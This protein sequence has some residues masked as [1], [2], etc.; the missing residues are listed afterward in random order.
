MKQSLIKKMDALI[1]GKILYI[2]T[3]LISVMLLISVVISGYQ[4]SFVKSEKQRSQEN[5][6]WAIA[7]FA[8]KLAEFNT[9]AE[10]NIR[11][12]GQNNKD[13]DF[14]LDILFSRANVIRNKSPSTK[15]LYK[16]PSYKKTI[17]SIYDR[18]TLIDNEIKKTPIRYSR[19]K[20]I[21]DSIS[22]YVNTLAN[23]ADHAEVKQRDDNYQAYLNAKSSL[24]HFIL[25][26]SIIGLL[27]ILINIRQYFNVTESLKS[28]KQAFDN[29]NAFIGML[30]HELRTSLQAIMSSVDLL[31]MNAMDEKSTFL[32]ESAASQMERQM[33]DLTEF[34]K[35]DNGLIEIR[36]N[37]F[38]LHQVVNTLILECQLAEKNEELSIINN[39]PSPLEIYAD[40]ARIAQII[41]NILSNAIKY[42]QHGHVKL[43]G[44]IINDILTLNI[45]DTGSGIPQNRLEQ[46]FKPFIRAN[47]GNTPGFGMGLAIVHG[48]T[49]RMGGDV[50]ITSEIN[51]GTTVIVTI[52]VKCGYPAPEKS[53]SNPV[54]EISLNILL[55]D[56][57][58]LICH[59]VK[60]LLIR[61]GHTVDSTTF[62]ERAWQKIQ[63]KPFDVI[64]TDL[65]MPLITGDELYRLT[66]K[67][68]GPNRSTPFVFITAYSIPQNTLDDN[69]TVIAKP[70]RHR[71]LV[72]AL[73]KMVPGKG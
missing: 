46:I 18:L 47:D 45:S 33:A 50:H 54:A 59:S 36:K 67:N 37:H 20:E 9:L 4:I 35:V 41:K 8:I 14:S 63:R 6:S 34:A 39:I 32:L 26:I 66:R 22:P 40:Q 15:W 29:K 61:S 48:L 42:T 19:I 52:P 16:E 49:G 64:L 57:N 30:G 27:V 44:E 71:D 31:K 73:V 53:L 24:N 69:C 21:S 7:K 38:N 55:V 5:Y 62:P 72:S 43:D 58:E 28:K 56:D 3:T 1:S 2:I 13:I 70:V 11:L 10:E 17:D 68:L 65:Q 25:A 12:N 23:I 51:V 60:S